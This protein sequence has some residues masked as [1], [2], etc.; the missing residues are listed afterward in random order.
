MD[1]NIKHY[2]QRAIDF[3]KE[4]N[5][6]WPFSALILDV[7]GKIICQTSDCAHISPLFH[8]EALAVHVL[9][10]NKTKISKPLGDLILVTTAEPDVLAQSAL[11]WANVAH[12]LSVTHVYSGATLDTIQRLWPFGIDIPAKEIVER[13]FNSNIALTDRIMEQECNDL[14]L[15]AKKSQEQ[16]DKNHPAMGVLSTNISDF[17]QINLQSYEQI[18]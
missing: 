9:I 11:H 18:T 1:I 12:D 6:I 5:P 3:A 8:A 15:E 17:Y 14:F 7:K 16:V 13:S 2:M 10:Q 4:K